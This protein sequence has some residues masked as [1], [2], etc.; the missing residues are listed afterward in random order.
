A[1]LVCA[2]SQRPHMKGCS[3]AR[4][5]RE[6]R[7]KSQATTVT[8]LA[9]TRESCASSFISNQSM[10]NS[11]AVQTNARSFGGLQTMSIQSSAQSPIATS[12]VRSMTAAFACTSLLG[13]AL[14]STVA[15]ADAPKQRLNPLIGLIEQG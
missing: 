1:T 4:E 14:A 9:R 11:N 6:M 5:V 7:L 3:G 10:F 15:C 12:I 2:V 8:L 13:I